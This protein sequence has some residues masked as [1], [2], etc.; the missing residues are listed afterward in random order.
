MI[1]SVGVVLIGLGVG[2]FVV[3]SMDH[4]L[5]NAYTTGGLLWLVVGCVTLGLALKVNH[6][7]KQ[8]IGALR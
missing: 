5:S 6:Q 1:L 4:T 7:K 2:F 8:Q 3:G